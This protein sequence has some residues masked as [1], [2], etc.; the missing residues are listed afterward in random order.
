MT[1][2]TL[3]SC[4]LFLVIN[5]HMPVGATFMRHMIVEHP[6][7]TELKAIALASHPIDP[8]APPAKQPMM[9]TKNQMKTKSHGHHGEEDGKHHHFHM[10]RVRRLKRFCN[11]FCVVTKCF[12]MITHLCILISLFKAV[13]T[14]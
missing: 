11:L 8:V 3:F 9:D 5:L 13:L 4:L 7:V 1:R 10:D 14:H 6:V 2:R 12:L